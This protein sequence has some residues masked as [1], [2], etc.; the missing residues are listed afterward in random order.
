MSDPNIQ[1][2]HPASFA[3]PNSV[4][5]PPMTTAET[6]S[7]IFF[8]PERT[9]TSLRERPR[10]LVAGVIIIAAIT[11]FIILFY[12]R[13]G[14]ENVVRQI[15]ENSSR[16]AQMSPEQKEQAIAMQ[17]KPVFQ[18]VYYFSP[19]IGLIIVFAAGAGLYLLGTMAMAKTISY[20]QALAVWTYSS[21]PPVLLMT[22]ANIALLFLKSLDSID[23]AKDSRGLVHANPSLLVDTVAHPVLGTALGA[24]DLF[25]FY[26]LFLAALG[27]RKVTRLSSGSAWAI[28]LA[29]WFAGV[30]VR[31]GLAAAFGS[32]MA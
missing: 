30:L 24:I 26:G 1:S 32:G 2:P 5:E 4:T 17:T 28:V 15:I 3:G 14:Y 22:L 11:L 25:S 20:R 27:L 19:A 7:G 12:Q 29:I 13:L 23:P 6:L 21:L 9:F 18:A 8:E 31:L 10:F 16:T